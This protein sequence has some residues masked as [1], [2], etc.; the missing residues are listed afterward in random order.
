[1][2]AYKDKVLRWLGSIRAESNNITEDFPDSVSGWF[3]L[4]LPGIS[5]S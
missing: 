2:E 4:R 5:F 3:R 1:M